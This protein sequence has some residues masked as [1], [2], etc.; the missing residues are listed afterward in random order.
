[1]SSFLY[2]RSRSVPGEDEEGI[3][4]ESCLEAVG[5]VSGRIIVQP[6]SVTSQ[7]HNLMSLKMSEKYRR[8]NKYC[9]LLM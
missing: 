2:T 7:A 4:A 6:S 1:M 8:G 3:K 9:M 5:A